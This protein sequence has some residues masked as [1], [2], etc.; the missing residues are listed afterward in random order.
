M[1]NKLIVIVFLLLS[2]EIIAQKKFMM[3]LD[4]NNVIT[5]EYIENYRFSQY[6]NSGIG[7]ELIDIVEVDEALLNAA[8]FFKINEFRSKKKKQLFSSSKPIQTVVE[9][10]MKKNHS[11]RFR[12]NGS[13]HYKLKRVLNKIPKY[14]WLRYKLYDGYTLLENVTDYSRGSYYLDRDSETDLQLFYGDK[15]PR[16]EDDALLKEINIIT[17][18]ELASKIVK[19]WLRRRGG[20]MLRSSS[21]EFLAVKVALDSKSFGKRR[22]LPRAKAIFIVGGFRNQ[23][24][25]KKEKNRKQREN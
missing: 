2:Y 5:N 3:S 18:N 25:Y 11:S 8:V 23:L 15:K 17:Y 22:R 7:D 13:N 16:L 10:Y 4:T 19:K 12:A 14:M 1:L 24:V 6:F 9:A 21:Y 20:G